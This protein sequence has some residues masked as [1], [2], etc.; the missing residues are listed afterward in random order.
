MKNGFASYIYQNFKQVIKQP[1]SAIKHGIPSVD[2]IG[3]I[4]I[5][6]EGHPGPGRVPIGTN[7]SN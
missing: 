7:S 1:K 3:P 6:L 5:N 2:T 4:R